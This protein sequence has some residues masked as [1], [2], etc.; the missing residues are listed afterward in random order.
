MKSYLH[1]AFLIDLEG[2]KKPVEPANGS[3]FSLE[4]LYRHLD[5]T[6]V[7]VV[8][9]IDGRIMIIDEEGKLK[10]NSKVNVKATLLY[11]KGFIE[12]I[13]GKAIVCHPSMFK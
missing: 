2:N 9:T 5:C 8:N 13:V 11:S 7:E 4:E 3:D 12:N 6:I 1:K 10:T